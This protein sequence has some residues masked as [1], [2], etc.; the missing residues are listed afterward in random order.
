MITAKAYLNS[1]IKAAGKVDLKEIKKA[2]GLL[3]KAYR[4]DKRV[5]V[6]GNGGSASNA[7]HFAQDLSKGSVPDLQGKRFRVMS[8]TDNIAFIT[9]VANDMGYEHVFEVQLRQF[10]KPGDVLMGI[11]GSG[12]SQNVINAVIYAKKLGMTV[13]GVTGFDGGK[14]I[15]MSD[16]RLHVPC[17]DMCKS[18]A[19]HGILFHM[20]ADMLKER[21]EK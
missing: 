6:I 17:H 21:F 3:E 4:R 11:S 15:K 2:V 19:V 16:I 5:F 7:T 12:N 13:V 9:A 20:I 10:A 1:V 8:L 18:E 14:L